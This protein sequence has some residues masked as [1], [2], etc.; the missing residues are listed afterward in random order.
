MVS[1]KVLVINTNGDVSLADYPSQNHRAGYQ[2]LSQV[3]G[4][5]IEILVAPPRIAMVINEEGKNE[6]LADNPVA[7]RLCLS[8]LAM[9]ERTLMAGDRIV[10]NMV[11]TGVGPEGTTV[12][13]DEEQIE[14]IN[15]TGVVTVPKE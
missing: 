5:F 12:G 13:I 4:G 6:G 14:A 15:R 3:V 7:T 10:G 8:L 9:D 2:M 1:D 11:V